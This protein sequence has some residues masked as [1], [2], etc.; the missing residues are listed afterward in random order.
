MTADE[1]YER[2]NVVMGIRVITSIHPSTQGLI[3]TLVEGAYALGE[4]AELKAQ[5]AKAKQP[6]VDAAEAEPGKTQPE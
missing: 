5:I 2:L 6:A 3:D 4:Q 1:I